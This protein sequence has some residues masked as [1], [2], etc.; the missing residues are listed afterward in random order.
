MLP[1]KDR[2]PSS[3]QPV[4]SGLLASASGERIAAIPLPHSG[5]CV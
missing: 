3:A 5:G 1:I 2:T 4:N